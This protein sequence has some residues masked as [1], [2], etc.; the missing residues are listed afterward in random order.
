MLTTA[1]N[2][3]Y[4]DVATSKRGRS[5]SRRADYCFPSIVTCIQPEIL[6]HH[7]TSLDIRSGF[8]TRFLF[9]TIPDGNRRPATGAIDH[10]AALAA[11][12]HYGRIEGSV[13]PERGYLSELH[14][15]FREH[16]AMPE[17][18]DRHV[19]E[20][21][22]R[23]ACVLQADGAEIRQETWDRTRTLL[24]WFYGM[25]ER[26]L[27]DVGTGPIETKFERFL[28][29][30]LAYIRRKTPSGGVTKKTISHNKNTGTDGPLRTRILDELVERGDIMKNSDGCYVATGAK[31]GERPSVRV[32]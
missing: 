20:Y 16:G 27:E 7:V 26:V 28:R 19:N 11:L 6:K 14:D 8:L 13:T 32:S 2:Q 10:S 17:I 9:S 12:E 24:L 23:I 31:G 18:Y 3:G 1:F 29:S 5:A 15:A 25:A 22:P 4:F 30:Y 21:G